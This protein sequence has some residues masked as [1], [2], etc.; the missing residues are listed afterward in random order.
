[1]QDFKISIVMPTYNSEKTI[2]KAL[3][4]IRAQ[5]IDQKEIEILIIDG[6]ST[7][8]TLDISRKYSAIILEN[9]E[10]FPESAKRIG[11]AYAH[12]E[13]I[14]MQDSDEVWSHRE[15]LV[16]RLRFL[17]RNPD[18]FCL[19][20]DKLVPG[21]HCGLSCPYLNIVSD[22]FGYI[23]YK[24]RNIKVEQNAKYLLKT[25]NLGN[26]YWYEK[27]DIIPIGDGGC[28]MVSIKKAK[29]LFGD[30]VVASQGFATSIFMQMV[31]ATHKV[32]I[33]P[34]DNIVHYSTASFRSYLK[35]LRF[36][37]YMN[38][39]DVEKSGYESKA[40]YN[41]KLKHRKILFLLYALSIVGPLLDSV[42][43]SV[44]Y[45]YPS[46]LLHFV[47]TYYICIVAVIEIIM[48]QLKIKGKHSYGK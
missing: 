9:P 25:S 44:L 21:K 8:K 5:T 23:V 47:Y 19:I 34:G 31:N 27:D 35:K 37:I 18:V 11:F 10:K 26:V 29:E 28:A 48:R 22:P 24:N 13:Y 14:V 1:M 15:Q 2:E 42:R 43:L 30:R 20:T 16:N 46:F 4:S 40:R 6:G 45:G 7:D 39:N 12:G 36:K 3:Q 17:E 32:G 38:L 41:R 33:I